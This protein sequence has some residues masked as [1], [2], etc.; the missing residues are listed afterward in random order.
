MDDGWTIPITEYTAEISDANPFEGDYSLRT[1]ITVAG[2]NIWS[3]SSGMQTVTIPA[4]ATQANLSFYLYPQTSDP[5][6][7]L[8]PVSILEAMASRYSYN[9]GDA[10]WVFVLDQNLTELERLVSMRS[11]AQTWQLYGEF[12]LLAYRGRTIVLYF[13]TF[14][15][16]GQG[17]T[18]MFVDNVSLE[19]CTGFGPQ[20]E[21]AN[22]PVVLSE[23]AEQGIYG[24]ILDSQQQP[25]AGQTVQ[26]LL[27]NTAAAAVL[28]ETTTDDA[29][30]Y[31]F[32]PLE[33]GAYVV[34]PQVNGFVFTPASREVTLPPAA[35]N[36]DFVG[37]P[38]GYP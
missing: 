7:M 17:I 6:N 8:I 26:L 35:E 11:N 15:N 33:D 21:S 37:S 2:D 18:S 10:Q 1:G 14:N 5:A 9:M 29:G 23:Y 28:E 34:Q 38:A 25:I 22:L 32:A 19:I 36:V 13:G 30:N 3:Y 16:G 24:T 27:S 12:D 20:D 31:S 4:D